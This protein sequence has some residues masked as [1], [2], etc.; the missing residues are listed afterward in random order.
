MGMARDEAQED[1][2]FSVL[3]DQV[4]LPLTQIRYATSTLPDSLQAEII[5]ATALAGLRLIDSYMLSMQLQRENQLQLEPVPISSLLYDTADQ[6]RE[7]AALHNCDIELGIAGKYEPVM[8]QRDALQAALLSLGY[9][10]I[11]ASDGSE[12]S[13]KLIRLAV[14]KRAGGITAGVYSSNEGLS[15]SLIKT[16]GKLAG[17]AHQTLPGF[18]SEAGAGILIAGRLLSQLNTTMRV[19]RSGGM[20]GLAATLVPSHQLTLV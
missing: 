12:G 4:K 17:K 15:S 18:T 16:A 19:A 2:L 10:F 3:A 13:R 9:G 7:Y 1:L 5:D 11:G 6:L 8:A 20:Q 14:Q